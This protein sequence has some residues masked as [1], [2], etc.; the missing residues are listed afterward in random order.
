MTFSLASLPRRASLAGLCLPAL[1]VVACAGTNPGI[2]GAASVSGPSLVP[3]ESAA[4]LQSG[5]VTEAGVG[6]PITSIQFFSNT[7]GSSCLALDASTVEVAGSFQVSLDPS[8]LAGRTLTFG[9]SPNPVLSLGATVS[10]DA[11]TGDDAEGFD[12]SFGYD[13]GVDAGA[14]A[15]SFVAVS[16]TIV[17]AASSSGNDLTGTIDAQMVLASSPGSNPVHVT[18]TFAAPICGD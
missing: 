18:G 14:P 1:A 6:A 7:P 15:A 11:G 12:A 3:I 4:L 8:T 10:A 16:G 17:F 13:A 9:S 5:A 2:T